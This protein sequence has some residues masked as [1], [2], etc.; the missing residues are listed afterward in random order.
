MMTQ[1]CEH[2]QRRGEVEALSWARVQPMRDDVQ[3]AL[4]IAREVCAR[5]Q[6]LPQQ[7]IGVL[8]GP[9]LP[10]AVR[11]GKEHVTGEPLGPAL[12]FRHLF[13]PIVGQRLAQRGRHVPEFPGESLAGTVR[14]GARHAGP[15]NQARRSFHEAAHGRG[16]SGPLDEVAFPVAGD[17]AA[18]H[19]RRADGNRRHVRDVAASISSPRPRPTGLVRLPQGRPPFAAQGAARQSVQARIDRLRRESLPPIVRIRVSEAPG[20][21]CARL[22][23]VD[24]FNL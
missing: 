2:L 21:V 20:N 22:E 17:G 15:N 3:L 11:I 5:G 16:V 13:A 14:I 23:K 18:R 6:I 4:R 24:A 19:F 10:G 1:L 12:V 7:A 8:V 9:A